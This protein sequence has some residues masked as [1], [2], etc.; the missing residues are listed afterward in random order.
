MQK[1]KHSGNY[2]LIFLDE[3][4]NLSQK[5][6]GKLL[7]VLQEREVRRLGETSARKVD[8]QVFAPVE[9]FTELEPFLPTI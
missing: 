8:V 2:F 5:L 1:E 4:S 3:I 6:Q 7:R 9:A